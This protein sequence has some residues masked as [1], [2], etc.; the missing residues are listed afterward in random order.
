MRKKKKKLIDLDALAG[1]PILFGGGKPKQRKAKRGTLGDRVGLISVKRHFLQFMDALF[2][3]T[4]VGRV[5]WRFEGDWSL[6]SRCYTLVTVFRQVA[7]RVERFDGGTFNVSISVDSKYSRFELSGSSQTRFRGSFESLFM[8][9][10]KSFDLL[11]MLTTPA[12]P[13]GSD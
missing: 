2:G 8:A 4:M 9:A 7:V 6:H 10:L 13:M 5:F 1:K 11:N 12:L 3:A